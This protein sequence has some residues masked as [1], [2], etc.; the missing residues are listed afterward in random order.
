MGVWWEEGVMRGVLVTF[1]GIGVR[2]CG[3]GFGLPGPGFPWLHMWLG[4][5]AS[6]AGPGFPWVHVCEHMCE[7]VRER[8][9]ALRGLG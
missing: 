5:W 6:G 1:W 4:V 8:G 3:L 9:G 7:Q 2:I